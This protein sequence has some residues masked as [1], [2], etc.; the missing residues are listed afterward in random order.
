MASDDETKQLLTSLAN[1]LLDGNETNKKVAGAL[2]KLTA[3]IATMPEASATLP[4]RPRWA[5]VIALS[6]LVGSTAAGG[7][8]LAIAWALS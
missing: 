6:A 2:E 4:V 3:R 8:W 5:V 1:H 7:A